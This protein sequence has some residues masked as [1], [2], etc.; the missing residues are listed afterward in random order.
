LKTNKHFYFL[1]LSILITT[2]IIVVTVEEPLN[3]KIK[4]FGN[5]EQLIFFIR[6][7]TPKNSVFFSGNNL[8]GFYVRCYGNRAVFGDYAF[9]F[10]EKY[11]KEYSFR[12]ISF[13]KFNTL[14]KTELNS[15]NKTYGVTH[16]IVNNNK[17][18]KYKDF[19]TIFENKY[20]S[21]ITFCE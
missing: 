16:L 1:I 12:Y 17:V 11:F 5:L 8:L 10:N 15:L 18:N 2:C 6:N 13:M 19:K 7:K 14:T 9:P 20:C 4:N 3:R 21:V